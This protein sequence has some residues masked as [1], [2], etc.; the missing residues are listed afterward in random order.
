VARSATAPIRGYFN[1]HFEML[2]QEI[3]TSGGRAG[4][5][6]A[7]AEPGGTAARLAELEALL[8]EQAQHQARVLARLGD[9]LGALTERI[10]ELERV[11]GRLAE[12]AAPLRDA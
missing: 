8:A 10:A 11:V 6:A 4:G 1:G 9:D 3:R 2:K 5:G 7:E 12:A